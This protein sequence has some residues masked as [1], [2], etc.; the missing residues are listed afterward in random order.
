MTRTIHLTQ[1]KISLVSDDDF[2]TVMAH[3]WH[4]VNF[5]GHWYAMTNVRADGRQKGLLMH[6]VLLNPPPSYDIDHINGDGLDNQRDNLRLATR[7]QN[8]A[9]SCRH[10]DSSSPW[11][12][13]YWDKGAGKW[14]AHIRING[15]KK[16]IGN[17]TTAEDAAK[18]Y[19]AEAIR[20]FGD[21]AKPNFNQHDHES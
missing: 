8:L 3:K 18:A 4:A 13:V 5:H 1:G 17:F 15:K 10:N 2:D 11:K 7:S 16:C 21:F 6:R 9:N 14:R 20:L 12:G 19:D